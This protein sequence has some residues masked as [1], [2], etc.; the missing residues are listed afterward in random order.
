MDLT[1]RQH[2]SF[3]YM[4]LDKPSGSIRINLDYASPEE[5]KWW[6]VII[7]RGSA[8]SIV[9]DNRYTPWAV[10]VDNLDLEIDCKIDFNHSPPTATQAAGY[11]ARLCV[12]YDLGN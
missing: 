5:L 4:P 1:E 10:S 7:A 6:N 11:L 8:Y 12:A 2:L 3:Q 9:G